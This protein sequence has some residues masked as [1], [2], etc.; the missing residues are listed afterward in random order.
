[1]VTTETAVV[2]S[3]SFWKSEGEEK[4][5]NKYRDPIP[6]LRSI[7]AV[8]FPQQ[9]ASRDQGV[10]PGRSV[11]LLC[12]FAELSSMVS[13]L[14]NL[15]LKFP[16]SQR[17]ADD[18]RYELVTKIDGGF[19]VR[20]ADVLRDQNI[21]AEASTHRG[22][23]NLC[24]LLAV[25][26]LLFG[27]HSVGSNEGVFAVSF[28]DGDECCEVFGLFEKPHNTNESLVNNDVFP[29]FSLITLVRLLAKLRP[30][31]V[32]SFSGNVG[33]WC[34]KLSVEKTNIV[35]AYVSNMATRMLGRRYSLAGA[36]EG[37]T[38]TPRATDA[39]ALGLGARS[40]ASEPS[41]VKSTTS[42]PSSS[43]AAR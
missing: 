8:Y 28:V 33:G 1:M 22:L 15:D 42:A 4:Q 24:S 23:L 2:S 38:E 14:G 11:G 3:V 32:K 18:I 19:H 10:Q 25:Q 31:L 6:S 34:L 26:L 30:I 17:Q 39:A 20:H 35:Y 16:H 9:V 37:V 21:F 12:L 40:V 7:S 41:L 29:T 43:R 27:E 36:A 13:D 5:K